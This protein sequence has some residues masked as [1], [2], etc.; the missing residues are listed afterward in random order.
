MLKR[1]KGKKF[2]KIEK[3]VLNKIQKG[4]SNK[5]KIKIKQTRS[6][7]NR[8]R[9]LFK[10]WFLALCLH[11]TTLKWSKKLGYCFVLLTTQWSVSSYTTVCLRI[12]LWGKNLKV[13]FFL[14]WMFLLKIWV[15]T[16]GKW[17]KFLTS[18]HLPAQAFMVRWRENS[19]SRVNW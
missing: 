15:I 7:V 8:N 10:S 17:T 5:N 6:P 2:L 18:Q 13:S 12:K 14:L 1:K 4:Y 9:C 19:D 3:K 11:C 16:F